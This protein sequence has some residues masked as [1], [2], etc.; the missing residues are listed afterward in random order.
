MQEKVG[1]ASCPA[2][3]REA[4]FYIVQAELHVSSAE[5]NDP[6]SERR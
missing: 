1:G 6:E 5:S 4:C 3:Q 2:P